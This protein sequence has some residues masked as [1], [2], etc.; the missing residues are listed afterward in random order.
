MKYVVVRKMDDGKLVD[1]HTPLSFVEAQ[2]LMSSFR[3][4]YP[5]NV[6]TVI[7]REV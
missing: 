3:K 2:E 1:V 5:Q 4:L 7:Q 6:Y